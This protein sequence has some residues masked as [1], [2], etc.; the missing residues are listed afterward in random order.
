MSVPS[1]GYGIPVPP[2]MNFP[3]ATL[4]AAVQMPTAEDG[5]AL[6]RGARRGAKTLADSVEQLLGADGSVR[7]E[8]VIA[9]ENKKTV[10]EASKE[11]DESVSAAMRGSGPLRDNS[12]GSTL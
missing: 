9:A 8:Y 11:V 1:G 5:L 3:E 12:E 4:P 7:V 2:E 6:F 10:T